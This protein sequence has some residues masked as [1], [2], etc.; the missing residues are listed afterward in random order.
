MLVQMTK[1][2]HMTSVKLATIE[3]ELHTAVSME[4]ADS[5]LWLLSD[6]LL[7]KKVCCHD[8]ELLLSLLL[9]RLGYLMRCYLVVHS[10]HHHGNIRCGHYYRHI[11][12]IK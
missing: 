2:D 1:L 11:M 5:L 3:I 4:M 12:M 6:G 9:S 7:I 8:N 10:V